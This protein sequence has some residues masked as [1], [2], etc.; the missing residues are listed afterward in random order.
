MTKWSVCSGRS[1]ILELITRKEEVTVVSPDAINRA[2][3]IP[4]LY[5]MINT[6]N[7]VRVNPTTRKE[8]AIKSDQ[9][10]IKVESERGYIVIVNEISKRGTQRLCSF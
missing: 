8:P 9:N 10:I 5:L 7:T 4:P 2:G 3:P 1:Y 6:P